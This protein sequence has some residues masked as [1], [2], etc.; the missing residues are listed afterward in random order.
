M[1]F[2]AIYSLELDTKLDLA[3]DFRQVEYSKN[4]RF[5]RIWMV[6]NGAVKGFGWSDMQILSFTIQRNQK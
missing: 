6:S 1:N 3:F 5:R 2:P 4:G